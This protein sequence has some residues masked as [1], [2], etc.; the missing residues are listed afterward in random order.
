MPSLCDRASDV[1]IQAGDRGVKKRGLILR[2]EPMNPDKKIIWLEYALKN[3]KDRNV[4]LT[5]AVET[6][7]S[8][9]SVVESYQERKVL[10]RVFDDTAL[11]QPM[12]IRVV[13][14]EELDYITVVTVF[15]TSN[16]KMYLKKGQ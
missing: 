2:P 9:D 14:E 1:A 7:N 11:G 16:A 4:P 3:L 13:I 8:P 12:L 10:M 15:K 5:E 6:L